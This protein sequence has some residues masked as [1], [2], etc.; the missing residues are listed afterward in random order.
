MGVT[1]PDPAEQERDDAYWIRRAVALAERARDA[2]EVPVGAVLVADGTVIGEG[3]NTCIASHDPTAHAEV[4]AIRN[5]G[6][7]TG[8]YRMPG[9]TLYVTLEP[10]AMCAGAIVL[11][12][13][14]RVVFGAHDPRS[15]AAGSV[16]DILANPALNHR[17]HATGG[18]EAD[19]CAALLTGFFRERRTPR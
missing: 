17:A 10:C 5:A 19:A 13:I 7:A 15:G 2:G 8:N 6:T 14:A 16:M 9:S 18:V 11:A 3:A 12:R 1:D 4:V